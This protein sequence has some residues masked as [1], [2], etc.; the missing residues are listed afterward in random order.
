M[1]VKLVIDTVR[2][3]MTSSTDS[4]GDLH[5]SIGRPFITKLSIKN[6]SWG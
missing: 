4:K 5:L 1:D 2:Q 3:R 6:G